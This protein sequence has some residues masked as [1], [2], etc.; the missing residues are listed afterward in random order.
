MSRLGYPWL[1]WF[2]FFKHSYWPETLAVACR[3]FSWPNIPQYNMYIHTYLPTY[4]PTYIHTYIHT[5]RHTH[6]DR[7]TYLPTY[8]HTYLHTYIPTYLHTYIHTYLRTYLRTYMHACM[9][10]SIHPSIHTYIH[11]Y[12]KVC[13]QPFAAQVSSIMVLSCHFGQLGPSPPISLRAEKTRMT[14]RELWGA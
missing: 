1:S 7:Q 13:M 5:Y 6:T 10:P 2:W 14:L 12:I 11:T 4:L 8:I 3:H 9:H